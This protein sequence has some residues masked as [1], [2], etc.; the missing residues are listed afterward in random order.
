[1][2]QQ[3]RST[4]LIA[5]VFSL[6]SVSAT[7]QNER[8][9]EL[10]TDDGQID[11]PLEDGVPMR[12]LSNGDI[13]ASAIPGFSCPTDGASCDDVQVSLAS[14]DGGALTVSPNP[15]TQGNNVSI[16]WT[17]VGAWE[18][19]GAGLSGTT[20]NSAN[21]KQASGQQSVNTGP[22]QAGTTHPVEVICANGPVTDTRTVM[23]TVEEDTIIDP[24]GCEDVP[25][26]REFQDWTL[27][28]GILRND[29]THDPNVFADI[30]NAPF[31]G[32]S[33]TAHIEIRKGRYA[34]IR[35][36]TPSGLNASH[37]GQFN[38]ENAGQIFPNGDKRIVSITKCPGVFDP[39]FVEQSACIQ[40]LN[41]TNEHRW[42]GPGHPDS[43][44]RCEL[45]ADTTY[46]LNIVFSR[47]ELGDFPPL[48]APCES[49]ETVCGGLMRSSSNL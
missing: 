32:T 29:D 16:G 7:A 18:C 40:S 22:L 8:T 9:L 14:A 13:S 30:F 23:L 38:S 12:I 24:P 31:P 10:Q 3:F 2:K 15:V 34:A 28:D 49:G 33:N 37:Q 36:T 45:Q 48:Q 17:G 35:F 4:A 21:P 25:E 5:I 11:V 1:M 26:L 41:M 46:Y 20:W 27:A 19:E 47:S 43:G 6:A 42:V 44:F 39:Q